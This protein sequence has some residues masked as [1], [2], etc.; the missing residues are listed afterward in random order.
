MAG[1]LAAR[2]A[3]RD[4][5]RLGGATGKLRLRAPRGRLFPL[6]LDHLLQG[7]LVQHADKSAERVV[8]QLVE[9]CQ[10]ALCAAPLTL[11]VLDLEIEDLHR[12]D[13][14]TDPDLRCRTCQSHTTMSPA[15]CLNKSRAR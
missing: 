10:L 13:H 11:V 2:R 15:N 7:V 6:Y 12:A 1:M 3:A 9:R 4:G 14:I 8:E 5:R